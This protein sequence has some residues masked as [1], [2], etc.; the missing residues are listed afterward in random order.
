MD[1]PDRGDDP[2][3]G[4]GLRRAGVAV[5]LAA[6]LLLLAAVTVFLA[7]GRPY[8]VNIGGGALYLLGVLVGLVGT[9]LLWTAAIDRPAGARRGFG[10]TVAALVLVCAC[11]VLSLGDVLAGQLQLVLITLTAV[12]LA[13]A[14][15]VARRA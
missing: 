15:L 4:A 1:R 5:C 13:A 6:A 2:G 9:V 3:A 10:L 12:V 14:A 11:P 7:G 8:G